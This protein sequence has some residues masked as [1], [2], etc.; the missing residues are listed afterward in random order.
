[1]QRGQYELGEGITGRVAQTGEMELVAD[2]SQSPDFLNRT[3]ARDDEEIAFIWCR[4][5]TIKRSLAR[6]ALTC[7]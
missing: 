3:K 5:F 6:L 7:P 1:M 2:V 4:L